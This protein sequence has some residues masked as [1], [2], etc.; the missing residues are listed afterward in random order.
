MRTTVPGT[1]NSERSVLPNASRCCSYMNVMFPRPAASWPRSR[2][3]RV[4]GGDCASGTGPVREPE[5][6]PA[7]DGEGVQDRR[8]ESALTG[9][10]ATSLHVGGGEWGAVKRAPSVEVEGRG[11]VCGLG[12]L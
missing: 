5:L 3:T 9:R 10:K 7:A 4:C 8:E 2:S 11:R 12:L 6:E 1:L